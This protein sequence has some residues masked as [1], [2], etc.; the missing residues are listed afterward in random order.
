MICIINDIIIDII[1]VF[2]LY[3]A[4]IQCLIFS[5]NVYDDDRRQWL[6]NDIDWYY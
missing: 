2:L 5:S 3:C 6:F 4:N 1:E